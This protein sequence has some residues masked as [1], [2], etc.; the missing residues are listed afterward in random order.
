M[1]ADSAAGWTFDRPTD[2]AVSLPAGYDPLQGGVSVFL[3]NF[4][5]RPECLA[6]AGAGPTPS[7]SPSPACLVPFA[8]IPDG[9]VYLEIYGSRTAS[10]VPS[11]GEQVTVLGR[12]SRL[13]IDRP[14]RC[15]T[16]VTDEVLKVP[17]PDGGGGGVYHVSVIACLVGPDVEQS[18][19]EFRA[20]LASLSEQ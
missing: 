13:E 19:R 14:G 17:V 18:E 8:T 7:P 15:A 10:Q 2:W 9:G 1:V 5:L 6:A 11:R 3:S 20:F 12:P 4:P 16:Q